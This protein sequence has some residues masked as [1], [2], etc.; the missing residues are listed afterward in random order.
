M[1]LNNKNKGQE[2]VDKIE[3][4]EEKVQCGYFRVGVFSGTQFIKRIPFPFSGFT[5]E[6]M[7]PKCGPKMECDILEGRLCSCRS[8]EADDALD[9]QP[10][11]EPF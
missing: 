3:K 6:C 10:D 4:M 1:L 11:W 5:T 8:L 7:S 9:K 2:V